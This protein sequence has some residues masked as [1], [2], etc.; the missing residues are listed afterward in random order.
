MLC[1]ICKE[2]DAKVH[3][4]VQIVGNK[5]HKVDLCGDCA[6]KNRIDEPS[7]CSL[8]DLLRALGDDVLEG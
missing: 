5:V 8:A 1:R 2:K 6:H 4:V 7:D 3:L